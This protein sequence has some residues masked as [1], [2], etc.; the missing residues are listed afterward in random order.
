MRLLALLLAGSAQAQK[1]LDLYLQPVPDALPPAPTIVKRDTLAPC[2]E[3]S[4]SWAAFPAKET[5]KH[6]PA[7]VAYDCLQS[8]PVD[9]E[10]DLKQIAELK[11]MLEFHTTSSYLKQD[12]KHHHDNPVDLF[13]GLEKI[14]QAINN[15]TYK[16]D[17]E[18]QVSI[19]RLLRSGNDFHLGFRPDILG[20]LR[21]FKDTQ[22][23]SVSKDGLA[24]PEIFVYS[25]VLGP[26]NGTNWAA[27]SIKTINGK[28]VTEYLN[29]IASQAS[30]HDPDARFNQLFPNPALA[31]IG[32]VQA[33]KGDFAQGDYEGEK[34]VLVFNNGS[35]TTIQN[36]A[37]VASAADFTNV[38]DGESFF[39]TFCTGPT[40][41]EATEKPETTPTPS[42]NAT[43]TPKVSALPRPTGGY[44][45]P[46]IV[47]S[48]LAL[49]GY[50][51]NGTGYDDVAILAMP[52][53]GPTLGPGTEEINANVETQKV[54][55]TFLAD[56]TS[57]GKKKLIVD[58]RGN[59]GGTIALGFDFFKQLFPTLVPYGASRYRAHE[60]FEIYS[61]A[62]ADVADNKTLAEE[63]PEL[64]LGIT[65]SPFNWENSFKDYYGPYVNNN[66]TFIA[67][68]RYDWENNLGGY[69]SGPGF[70]LTGYLSNSKTS[71]Q[72]FPAENIVIMTDGSCGS[73]CAIFAELMREQGQVQFIAVGG[74]P[75]SAPMQGVGGTKGAQVLQMSTFR[76]I[77]IETIQKIAGIAS[78]D[79]VKAVNQSALGKLAQTEQLLIRS[80]HTSPENPINGVVNSLDNLRQN[81]SSETPL[82]FIY[83][84]ADCKLFYT[85]DALK[86][87]TKLWKQAVDIKWGKG[88]CV[89]GSTGDKSSIGVVSNKP[90][91]A[92]VKGNQTQQF[93]GVASGLKVSGMTGTMVVAAVMGVALLL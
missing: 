78:L 29:N 72:P 3:V 15:G 44:P 31:S 74:R 51:L 89:D 90:F 81:D 22:L 48:S 39:D 54:I 77:A 61:A 47:Q 55:R 4:V 18:V 20:I 68:R 63:E 73:T 87:V 64:Y 9:R 42:L 59:T 82:E 70:N 2:A 50:Y 6:V 91:N 23:V 88:K 62:I 83:E 57:K 66:D 67:P 49:Q 19:S 11:G 75:I 26:R 76:K 43:S 65:G 25:D 58:L 85:L 60:A 46:V 13:G 10:G 35:T 56:A 53:F 84:A 27:S 45:S 86:D 17:Y 30:F 5:A 1:I 80:E 71:S 69:P 21:F 36:T 38:T 40:E 41:T 28:N 8:V 37:I 52:N 92:Q 79:V 34:T 93:T 32:R 24:L 7:K 16:S 33:G 12:I 14:A